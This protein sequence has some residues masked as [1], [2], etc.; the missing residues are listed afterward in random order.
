M[1][2]TFLAMRRRGRLQTDLLV[3]LARVPRGEDR[4]E[5]KSL[6]RALA[7]DLALGFDPL[8]APMGEIWDGPKPEILVAQSDGN[9]R[10]IGHTIERMEL[11]AAKL[12]AAELHCNPEWTSTKLCC[13]KLES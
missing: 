4:A 1:G 12:V 2:C 8:S 6:I 10:H 9:W 13:K 3:A 11:L 5:D 7:D